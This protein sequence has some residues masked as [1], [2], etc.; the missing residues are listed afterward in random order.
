VISSNATANPLSAQVGQ[1][2][3]FNVAGSDADGDTL[4]YTWNFGDGTSSTGA[5][6][7]H[8]YS[9]AG[10]Y[11]ASVT[12]SDGR[13]GSASSSVTVTIGAAYAW[14][15]R[16]IGAVGI[17]GSF[18]QSGGTYTL[19]GAGKELYGN[20]DAFHFVYQTLVGN[21]TIVARV[22]GLNNP[23]EWCQA[24]VMMRETLA[25]N[26]RHV[27]MMAT[28]SGRAKF[29]RRYTVGGATTS[30]GP[31]AGELSLPQWVKLVR[32][33]NTFTGYRS[34]DGANWVLMGTDTVTM[35]STVYIGLYVTSA[36]TNAL[37][38]ATVD[39]VSISG[40]VSASRSLDSAEP[41][42]A[43]GDV[44]DLG[45]FS[46]S[47]KEKIFINLPGAEHLQKAKWKLTDKKALPPGVKL[48]RGKAGGKA[49]SEGGYTFS[50]QIGDVT[51]AFKM[52]V[53]K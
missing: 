12:V 45:V 36:V 8:A 23:N 32:S 33:G 19:N 18:S 29:R 34:D 26:S 10:T 52:T 3:A 41:V 42:V 4:T 9:A 51:Q 47:D 14:A 35:S 48:N 49:L 13:G 27:T 11:T 25:D 6:T 5:S 1:S 40:S 22:R 39:S 30:N 21:G 43:P 15:E 46:I 16:D 20:V 24:G 31:G 50:A 28:V 53:T 38:T 37:G 44:I 17:A 7:S 2:I